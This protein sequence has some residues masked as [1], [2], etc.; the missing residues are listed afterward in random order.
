MPPFPPEVDSFQFFLLLY[1]FLYCIHYSSRSIQACD[2]GSKIR[3]FGRD[4]KTM[5]I[6][7]LEVD[8]AYHTEYSMKS[9]RNRYGIWFASYMV[10][11]FTILFFHREILYLI[12]KRSSAFGLSGDILLAYPSIFQ[13]GA[14]RRYRTIKYLLSSSFVL[15]SFVPGTSHALFFYGHY[16]VQTIDYVCSPFPCFVLCFFVLGTLTCAVFPLGDNRISPR[17]SRAVSRSPRA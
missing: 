15:C 10:R 16:G 8:S 3:S 13:G 12:C 4:I 1:G 6:M 14:T 9:I 7:S 17:S 11:S 5:L 2:A